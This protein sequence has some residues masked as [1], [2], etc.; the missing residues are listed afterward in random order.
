MQLENQVIITK[1]AI[2]RI[3][4]PDLTDEERAKRMKAIEQAA[5]NLALANRRAEASKNQGAVDR[6]G[7]C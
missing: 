5:I 3:Y 4:H 7:T 1:N 2:I 6:C